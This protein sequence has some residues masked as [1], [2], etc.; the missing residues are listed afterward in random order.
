M[1]TIV[2]PGTITTPNT[3]APIPPA[4]K[5]LV[6]AAT[7]GR[8]ASQPD[9]IDPEAVAFFN[10]WLNNNGGVIFLRDSDG[11]PVPNPRF[12]RIGSAKLPGS[13]ATATASTAAPA[14]PATAPD[15]NAT[16]TVSGAVSTTKKP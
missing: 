3:K 4:Y 1:G 11:R 6:D 9:R 7:F 12:F 15:S 14:A 10:A 2:A 8:L 5:G 13:F 16:S